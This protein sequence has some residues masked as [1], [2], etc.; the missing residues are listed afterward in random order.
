LIGG[1][2]DYLT[3]ANF[4]LDVSHIY[5][6]DTLALS[7]GLAFKTPSANYFIV[8]GSGNNGQKTEDRISS[9]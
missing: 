6:L 5:S 2:L 8:L 1:G 7:K 4:L 9:I 3:W